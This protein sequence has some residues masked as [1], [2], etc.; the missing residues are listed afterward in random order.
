M[1]EDLEGVEEKKEKDEPKDTKVLVEEYID[2]LE[3]KLKDKQEKIEELEGQLEEVRKTAADL[4]LRISMFQQNASN[5][6]IATQKKQRLFDEYAV[7]TMVLMIILT[8]VAIPVLG[9]VVFKLS[10]LIS[11]IIG[12]AGFIAL[13]CISQY[14]VHEVKKI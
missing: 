4:E 3:Q 8:W 2:G 14:F 7:F 6:K 1:V 9:V 11:F 13:V 12:A 10:V 5:S